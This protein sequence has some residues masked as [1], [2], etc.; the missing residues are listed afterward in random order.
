ML[1]WNVFYCNPNLDKLETINVLEHREDY[2]KQLKKDYPIKADF[3]E[4]LRDEMM[5][6]YWAKCEW[7]TIISPWPSKEGI[8]W[9]IDI[10][11]QLN[12]NWNN[13]VDYCWSNV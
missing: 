8:E 4:K 10:F 2:L 3:S 9:K 1:T 7:E 13:F 5:Y 12:L 6:H 11:W